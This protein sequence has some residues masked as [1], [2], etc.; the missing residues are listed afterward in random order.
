MILVSVIY[1]YLLDEVSSIFRI[2]P[3]AYSVD[4]PSAVRHLKRVSALCLRFCGSRKEDG[5]YSICVDTLVGIEVF[6][7]AIYRISNWVP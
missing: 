3:S 7:L 1:M 2:V 5:C 6:Y 4:F